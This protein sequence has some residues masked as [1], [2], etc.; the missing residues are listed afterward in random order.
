MRSDRDASATS[1][2]AH[3]GTMAMLVMGILLMS[4]PLKASILKIAW[5]ILI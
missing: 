1:H 2:A 5:W 4:M 3:V